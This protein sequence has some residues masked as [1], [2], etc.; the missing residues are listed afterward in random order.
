M[1]EMPGFTLP[2][3][4]T[5][6][7][8]GRCRGCGVRVLWCRTQTGRG[9]AIDRDGGEHRLRCTDAERMTRGRFSLLS[10]RSE[11]REG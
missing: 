1:T 8:V 7:N 4:W 2:P 3:G 6:V 10:V 11:V 9:V 5:T